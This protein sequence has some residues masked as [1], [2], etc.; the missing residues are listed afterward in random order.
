MVESNISTMFARYLFIVHPLLQS[1]KQTNNVII[2]LL[3]KYLTISNNNMKSKVLWNAE[4]REC[5]N[6]KIR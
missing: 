2:N 5:R 1:S 3:A 6:S 4:R